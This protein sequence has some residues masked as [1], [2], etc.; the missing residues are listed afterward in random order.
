MRVKTTPNSPRKAV[1]LVESV[2]D[3]N[4]VRQKI[5]RHIGIARDEDQ[6]VKL[7]DLAEVI[8][9]KL[10]AD[11][12]PQLYRPEDVA[13]QVIAAQRHQDEAPLNVNL[14]ALREIQRLTSGIHAVYGAVYESLGLNRLLPAW[15]YRAPHKTLFHT[16]MARL[17]NPQSKR[18]GVRTLENDFGVQVSLPQVDRMMNLLDATRIENLNKLAGQQARA[19]LRGPLRILFFYCTTMYFESF[20]E[21][22]LKQPGYSKDAK[23]RGVADSVGRDRDRPAGALHCAAR[24]RCLREP[25]PHPGGQSVTRRA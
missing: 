3:G 20:T 9:A 16:V 8:K 19:L 18:A 5:V 17:A 2:R 23:Y 4:T 21:D 13:A 14:K 10:Q 15:G 7:K 25:E 1:Q 24:G 6:L 12:Q 11:T 22:D